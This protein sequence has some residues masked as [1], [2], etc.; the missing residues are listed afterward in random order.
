MK[1]L[2]LARH[3][4]SYRWFVGLG[5][6]VILLLGGSLSP[7]KQSTFV[8]GVCLAAVIAVHFG[9]AEDRKTGFDR[10]LSNYVRPSQ[11]LLDRVSVTAAL[12]TALMC[13]V[14]LITM[15]VWREAGLALWFTAFGTLVICLFLPLTFFLEQV[16]DT[17]FPMVASALLLTVLISWLIMRTDHPQPVINFFGLNVEQGSFRSL[18]HLVRANATWNSG[19]GLAGLALWAFRHRPHRITSRE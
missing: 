1:Q 10:L 14:L 6:F 9:I 3:L 12:V 16:L 18:L 19:I 2:Y 4:R 13:A 11:E 17:A 15:V 5:A 7:R 8:G